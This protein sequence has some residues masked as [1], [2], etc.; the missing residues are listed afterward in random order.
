MLGAAN[1]KSS[2][3]VRL[4]GVLLTPNLS[5]DNHVTSLSAKCF[6]HLR[7][8]RRIRRSLDDDSVATLVHAF[9]ATRVDYCIGLL[10][11]WQKKTT[12]KLQ[13]VL[14]AAAWAVSNC[15]KYNWGLIIFWRHVLHWL[16]VTDWISFRLCIQVYKCRHSMAPGHL[17][18]LCQTVSSTKGCRHLRS[19]SRG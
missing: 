12:A 3:V 16:D 10:A 7:Q 18:D 1:I 17:I 6:F 5:M 13:R 11:G 2:D 4:L 19:V 8:L 9:V 15:G 14:D